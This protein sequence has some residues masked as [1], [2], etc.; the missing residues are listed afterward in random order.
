M[1]YF[2]AGVVI[3]VCIEGVNAPCSVLGRLVAIEP[4]QAGVLEDILGATLLDHA[5]L[6]AAGALA[7]TETARETEEN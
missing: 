5:Q 1:F 7:G 6:I 3:L 4:A 2:R